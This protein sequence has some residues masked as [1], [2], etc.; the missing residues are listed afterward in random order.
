MRTT[1]I[2]GKIK[3]VGGIPDHY[4]QT[5]TIVQV[6]KTAVIVSVVAEKPTRSE[7]TYCSAT[8]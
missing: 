3:G 5:Y 4:S 7:V 1:M 8:R 2:V 6:M